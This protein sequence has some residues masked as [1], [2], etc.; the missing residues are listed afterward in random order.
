MKINFDK[1]ANDILSLHPTKHWE[2]RLTLPKF[3]RR[4]I[5]GWN[6]WW[7]YRSTKQIGFVVGEFPHDD[8]ELT[9]NSHIKAGVAIYLWH[10]VFYANKWYKNVVS[11]GI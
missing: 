1:K 11:F 10:Y 9:N 7:Q 8:Y 6:L 5:N 3:L 4:P 2:R